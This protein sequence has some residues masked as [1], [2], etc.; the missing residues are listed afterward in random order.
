[1]WLGTR[2]CFCLL[3][4]KVQYILLS[5]LAKWLSI[6]SWASNS[7]CRHFA[8]GVC[9]SVFFCNMDTVPPLLIQLVNDTEKNQ[10]ARETFRYSSSGRHSDVSQEVTDLLFDRGLSSIHSLIKTNNEN[11]TKYWLIAHLG[12]MIYLPHWRS[13]VGEQGISWSSE[14]LS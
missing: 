14:R 9:P 5:I 4:V 12:S 11:K 3:D 13:P 2:R 1:M 8:L 6:S 10:N 7:S